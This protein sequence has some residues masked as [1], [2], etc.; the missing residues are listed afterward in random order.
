MIKH[1]YAAYANNLNDKVMRERCMDAFP[2]DPYPKEP[3]YIKDMKLVFLADEPDRGFPTLVPCEGSKVPVGIWAISENDEK[4][5]DAYE[6]CPKLYVK[7]YAKNVE[8]QGYGVVNPMLYVLNP[9]VK[10]EGYGAP[11]KELADVIREGYDNWHL[12]KD[13]LE[14]AIAESKAIGCG[15]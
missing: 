3:A 12:D 6:Y 1:Y 8:V 5:L 13:V 9:D 4:S 11:S 10:F 14:N 15:K 2:H 7:I